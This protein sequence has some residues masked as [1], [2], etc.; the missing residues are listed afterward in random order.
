MFRQNPAEKVAHEVL[1]DSYPDVVVIMKRFDPKYRSKG[2]HRDRELEEIIPAAEWLQKYL[3]LGIKI[4]GYDDYSDFLADRYYV[5]HMI[6]SPDELQEKKA[7]HG[8]PPTAT[9]DEVVEAEIRENVRNKQTL[10]AAM[11][12]DSW[13]YGGSFGADGSFIPSRYKTVY[14]EPGTIHKGKGVP[15]W[16]VREI[17]NREMGLPP[18]R[19]I[20]KDIDVIYFNEKG[21]RL[22]N[23]YGREEGRRRLQESG[24]EA[25]RQ[26]EREQR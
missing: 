22:T 15:K 12:S 17:E 25:A 18:K 19:E 13:V 6:N 20:P 4:E 16:V 1:A 26:S 2:G 24:P 7:W 11:A 8:L 21:Q 3:D 5:Y 23:Q 10:N 14:V 9:L